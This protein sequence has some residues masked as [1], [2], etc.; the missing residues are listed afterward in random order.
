MRA[1]IPRVTAIAA[2]L[3]ILGAAPGARADE[4]QACIDASEA[5]QQLRSDGKLT[6]ARARLLACARPECPGLVRQDCSQWLTEVLAALPSVVLGARDAQGRDRFDVRVSIDG[7]PY[8]Q[9][10][11]GKPIVIDPGRHVFRYEAGSQDA[12]PPVELDVL[13]REGEKNRELT[14]TFPANAPPSPPTAPSTVAPGSEGPPGP[15]AR[16]T[17]PLVWLFGGMA[18]AA[19]GTSLAFLVAQDV[20]YDRLRARCGGH[21]TPDQVSPVSTE[22]TVAAWTAVGGGVSLAIGAVLWFVRSDRAAPA[23]FEVVPS[24]HGAIG[25]FE[26]RF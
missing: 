17:P 23:A 11:D 20:E 21:C 9:R 24:P 22:R 8:A 25:S 7:A 12:S 1:R 6:E 2:A 13:V 16:V 18:A 10:L 3:A 5:A 15:A 19:L 26:G 14:A 4:K